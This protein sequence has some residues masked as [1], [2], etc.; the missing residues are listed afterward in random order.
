MIAEAERPALVPLTPAEHTAL[1]H[2]RREHWKGVRKR[3]GWTLAAMQQEYELFR[4]LS[5]RRNRRDERELDKPILTEFYWLV[6]D[7]RQKIERMLRNETPIGFFVPS[8]EQAQML[9]AWFPTEDSP[10]GR[11]TCLNFGSVRGGK[12]SATVVN[13]QLWMIPNDPEWMMF[14]WRDDP[15]GRGRY[16][17]EPRW[18]WDEWKRS[19]RRVFDAS[20]APKSAC[21]IWHGVPD[22]NHWKTKLEKEYRKWLPD[23]FI[24]RKGR[25]REWNSTDKWFKT[26]NGSVLTAK[27]YNSEMQSWGGHELFLINLDEGPPQDKLEEVVFR[28]KYLQWTYTP[29]E[30][31]NLGGRS[32]VA[33]NAWQ[34]K[35]RLTGYPDTEPLR[36]LPKMEEIP[37]QVMDPEEKRKRIAIAES[38]GDRGKAAM[39]YGFFD[40]SPVVFNNF[41][42]DKH[43]LP[44]GGAEALKKWPEAIKIRGFDEGTAHPTAV[45]WVMILRT[46]EYVVYRDFAEAGLSVTE[47]CV[48]IIELSRNKRVVT[49]EHPDP[50]KIRYKEQMEGEVIRRTFADSKIFRRNPETVQDDWVDSYARKGLRLERATNIGPAARCDFVN[51]MF[52]DDLTRRHLVTDLAPGHKLYVCN[53]CT[54]LIERLENY[55]QEQLKSGPNKG[56]FTGQPQKNKDD[57]VDAFCYAACSKLRWV[58][59]ASY[60]TAPAL[61]A[62]NSITGY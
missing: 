41:N 6:M 51:D 60:A 10:L 18:N 48:K 26:K 25:D 1:V 44:F 35:T 22:E 36:I 54:D 19:G 7:E 53:D 43:V 29:R 58:D 59:P 61:P 14:E 28:T 40:S 4:S 57:L 55:L 20:E 11:H 38:M 47:R 27:L 49:Q 21:E 17:V 46:G 23:R 62:G 30:A 15:Y 37:A 33:K 8:Y 34:N 50:D 12:T 13:A 24:A 3:R 9:N 42:R 32:L 39:G 52:L 31:A 2:L 45:A 16:R 56:D 5:E